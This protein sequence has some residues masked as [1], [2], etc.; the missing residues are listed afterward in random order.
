MLF[1]LFAELVRSPVITECLAIPLPPEALFLI[2]KKGPDY[3]L[4]SAARIDVSEKA[5]HAYAMQ[6]NVARQPGKPERMFVRRKILLGRC[7]H[8]ERRIA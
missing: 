1:L 2:S 3:T 7:C 8:K 6:V 4:M 5:F